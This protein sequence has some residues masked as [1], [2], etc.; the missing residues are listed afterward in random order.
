MNSLVSL[1][2]HGKLIRLQEY[3]GW[4]E[5]SLG[6]HFRRRV[7]ARCVSFYNVIHQRKDEIKVRHS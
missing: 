7:L 5:S 3:T 4:F 2:G 1:C 6:A